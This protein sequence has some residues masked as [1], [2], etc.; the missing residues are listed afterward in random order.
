MKK[1]DFKSLVLGLVIGTIGVS[2]VFAAGEIKSATISKSKVYFYGNEVKLKN[3]LISIVKDGSSKSQL[4]M[5]MSELL[6]YMQFKVECNSKDN[7]V[8]LTMNGD[9]SNKNMEV[10]PDISKNQADTKAIAVM[11][12]TG[13]WRYIQPYLSYMS[14]DG[15]KRVVEIYNSKHINSS[16]HK[17]A[18]DYIQE[19][20][21]AQS[22]FK[23]G[24]TGRLGDYQFTVNTVTLTKSNK[25]WHAQDGNKLITI[26]CSFENVSIVQY[27]MTAITLFKLFD[28]NGKT[29]NMCL[30][31][32]NNGRMDGLVEAG[33]KVT[34]E[35]TFE[36]PISIAEAQLEIHPILANKETIRYILQIP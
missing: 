1:F 35:I 32:N 18:S 12:K 22:H 29:Y 15:I 13:N 2:T 17:K 27:G 10:T 21:D 11:Q 33:K 26:N 14:G 36:V 24:E 6:E 23:V 30:G 9:N 20:K 7:S 3:P 31:G 34:G 5:P 28:T 4:Y 25:F 19:S 8:N 16:E